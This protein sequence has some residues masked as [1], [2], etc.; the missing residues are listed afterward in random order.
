MKVFNHQL[1]LTLT[2]VSLLAQLPAHLALLFLHSLLTKLLRHATF[3]LNEQTHT[4]AEAR[5]SCFFSQ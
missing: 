2:A 1:L 4:A 3:E 5:T